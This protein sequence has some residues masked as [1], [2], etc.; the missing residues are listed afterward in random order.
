MSPPAAV[1]TTRRNGS[2]RIILRQG[3]SAEC[4]KPLRPP[5]WH[6]HNAANSRSLSPAKARDDVSLRQNEVGR[7]LRRFRLRNEFR[8]RAEHDR[9]DDTV[10]LA[11]LR[12]IARLD[13]LVFLAEAERAGGRGQPYLLHG[14]EER[15]F[16][17]KLSRA[18]PERGI[19]NLP[20]DIAAHPL[21]NGLGFVGGLPFLDEGPVLRRIDRREVIRGADKSERGLALGRQDCLVDGRGEAVERQLLAVVGE[22]LDETHR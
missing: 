4:G 13:W 9:L 20:H 1:T 15:R 8:D 5:R 14:R 6:I 18:L 11:H 10:H 22:L 3:R 17:R 21:P 12:Y 2:C 7:K 19:E 16:V